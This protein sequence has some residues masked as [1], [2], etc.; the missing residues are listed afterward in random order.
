MGVELLRLIGKEKSMSGDCNIQETV[1][2][3]V[4]G[5]VGLVIGG[6]FGGFVGFALGRNRRMG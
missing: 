2:T 5:I 1:L 3:A 4:W 6:F